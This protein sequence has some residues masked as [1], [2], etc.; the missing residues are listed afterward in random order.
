VCARPKGVPEGTLEWAYGGSVKGKRLTFSLTEY[1]AAA[2][3]AETIFVLDDQAPA[4]S[5]YYF[6][7]DPAELSCPGKPPP[8]PYKDVVASKLLPMWSAATSMSV[9]LNGNPKKGDG[10]TTETSS[11]DGK[12]PPLSFS[13]IL[14]RNL[15]IVGALASGDTSGSLKDPNGSRYGMLGG[16][17]VGGPDLQIL[18][19]AAGTFAIIGIPL[20]T[21][22]D[23]ITKVTRALGQRKA[24]AILDP[25][26]LSREIAEKLAEEPKQIDVLDAIEALKRG[27]E[28]TLES[29][30]KAMAISLREAQV[31][32]PYSRAQIFTA[33]WEAKYQA[34]HIFE[35]R[36]M[37]ELGLGE[38]AK[39]APAI[40]LSKAEHEAITLK[41]ADAGK[42]LLDNVKKTGKKLDPADVWQMYQEVYKDQ[43]NWLRAIEGYFPKVP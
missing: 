35:V 12:G 18:Q 34:H 3:N 16:K 33:G 8:R 42:M 32:L 5:I 7:T 10:Q 14:T 41:L 27:E 43:P 11:A 21:G 30:G 40:I 19:A 24:P 38:A 20:K 9:A 29:F 4:E 13:E 2:A 26:V 15:S 37:K 28:I 36:W 22:K 23:L 17:N 39:D 6:V 31:I 25:K 1:A